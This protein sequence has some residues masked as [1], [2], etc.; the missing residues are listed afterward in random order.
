MA[1]LSIESVPP[2]PP[3]PVVAVA[4]GRGICAT[5]LYDYEAEEENEMSLKEGETIEE[6]EEID[7]G[8]IFYSSSI[9]PF[10]PIFPHRLV[11]RRGG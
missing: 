11:V 1:A 3:P 7:E 6:I 9:S 8:M 10:L 2:P 5:V 4:K